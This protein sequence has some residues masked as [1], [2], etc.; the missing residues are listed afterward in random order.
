MKTRKKLT[1]PATGDELV[2]L[3]VDAYGITDGAGLVLVQVAGQALDSALEAEALIV[4]HGMVVEGERGLRANPAC[5]VSRDSRNRLLAA[6][7]KLNLEL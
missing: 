6:L 4:R 2:N 1:L 3:L 5:A 7:G